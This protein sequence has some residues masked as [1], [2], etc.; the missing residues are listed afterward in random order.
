M[1]EITLLQEKLHYQ[2][3]TGVVNKKICYPQNEIS[4][5]TRPKVRMLILSYSFSTEGTS[6]P[7]SD[8]LLPVTFQESIRN[9]VQCKV[10]HSSPAL[11]ITLHTYTDRK[12]SVSNLYFRDRRSLP[13]R[14]GSYH[15][16]ICLLF[17]VYDR[18]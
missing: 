17:A 4:I 6:E 1:N 16:G 2:Y 8:L 3:C 9:S 13:V 7:M 11:G 14:P 10:I 5:P 15:E 18:I 12:C